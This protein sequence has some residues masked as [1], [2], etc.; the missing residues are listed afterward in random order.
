MNTFKLFLPILLMLSFFSCS[1]ELKVAAEWENIPVVYAL[2]DMKEDVNYF[3]VE[4]AFI[5]PEISGQDIAQISDSLYY[6]PDVLVRLTNTR[7]TNSVILERVNLED[8]GFIRED[9]DFATSPN[10]G[11]K[12]FTADLDMS[13]DD[14]IEFELLGPNETVYT[15]GQTRVVGAYTIPDG[16]PGDPM[17]FIEERDASFGIRSEEQS[18]RFFDCRLFI[19]Y[20][21]EKTDNPGVF[22]P[23]RLE[24]IIEQGLIRKKSS[25]TDLFRSLTVFKVAGEEFYKYL[26]AEIPE[27]P[28]VARYYRGIDIRYDAGGEELLNYINI[29][30]ANTGITSN[31]LIPTYTNL[32]ND[33]LGVFSS[34]TTTRNLEDSYNINTET[35]D[36]LRD[37]RF[38]RRLNFR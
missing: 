20:D 32:N 6:G 29:G 5:D 37:G 27:D 1:N 21:E 18:A 2:I 22:T 33:A 38:T 36:S 17:R 12:L 19:N 30:L 31:Q 26:A 7:N 14:L 4:K 8:E 16:Q 28:T 13:A 3:R 34:R 35:R 10:I 25:G 11:Y 15:S 23:K 24:W 9:G